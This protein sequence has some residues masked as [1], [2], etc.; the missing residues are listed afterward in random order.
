MTIGMLI[1][2][3]HDYSTAGG[4][5]DDRLLDSNVDGWMHALLP[6]I[7]MLLKKGACIST[8]ALNAHPTRTQSSAI[9]S[10]YSM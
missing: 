1:E 6:H 10:Q 3:C 7:C 2:C 8:P 9:N 5:L 4:G